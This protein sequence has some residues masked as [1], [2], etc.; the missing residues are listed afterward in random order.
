LGALTAIVA[1]LSTLA[2]ASSADT[3]K[4]PASSSSSPARSPSPTSTARIPPD[5]S[6]LSERGQWV[7]DLRWDKGD[8][9]LLGVRRIELAA[10][11]TT[12]RAMGRFALELFE[13]PTLIERV[14]FDFPLLGVG[15]AVDAG[16]QA[17]P[18]F[19]RKLTT[20]IGVMFPATIKGT[21]L[22]LWD[23]ATDRRWD[24]SWPPGQEV[25]SGEKPS[26]GDAGASKLDGG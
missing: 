13:G 20:R 4:A 14:R 24:L 1:S 5:P 26:T 9:Y 11:Q 6:P 18:S 19:E 7:F 3:S 25:S 17:P 12:P 8:V 10:P 15:D 22:Q 16:R 2:V 21:K 23:R